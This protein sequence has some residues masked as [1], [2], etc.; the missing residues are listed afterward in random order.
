[1]GHIGIHC[2]A[3]EDTFWPEDEPYD[4]Y[5]FEREAEKAAGLIPPQ[6]EEQ[7]VHDLDQL[8]LNHSQIHLFNRKYVEELPLIGGVSLIK[9]PKDSGKTQLLAKLTTN[10]PLRILLIGHRRSLIQ[11]MCNRL[12]LHC[13]LDDG[14]EGSKH[15]SKKERQSQ[16]GVCVDSLGKLDLA[17]PYDFVLIDESEQVLSHFSSKTL[18]GKR[19]LMF[20]YFMRLIEQAK[21]VVAL[22]A[23]LSWT[24]ANFITKWARKEGPVKPCN[25]YLNK[26]RVER[27]DVHIIEKKQQIFGEIHQAIEA[28]QKIYVAAN[29]R[30]Q[31]E[32]IE[33]AIRD[34]SPLVSMLAITSETAKID[35][36]DSA[37]RDFLLAPAIAAKKYQVILASP[38]AGTGIDITFDAAEIYFD[39]VFGIFIHDITSHFDCD[40]QLARV[41]HPGEVRVF[42]SPRQFN[43]ETNMDVMKHDVI[44]MM[45]DHLLTGLDAQGAPVYNTNDPLL[46]LVA[47][48]ASRDRASINNLKKNFIDYKIRQGWT[49]IQADVDLEASE[50][51]VL[52]AERGKEITDEEAIKR[53]MDARSMQPEEFEATKKILK[54][55]GY[56]SQQVRLD[57]RRTK[58]ERSYG[59]DITPEL[60][61]FDDQGRGRQKVGLFRAATNKTALKIRAMI[62]QGQSEADVES[63]TLLHDWPTVQKMYLEILSTLPIYRDGEFLFDTYFT[64]D[65]LGEFVSY[66]LDNKAVIEAQFKMEVRRDLIEKP[67]TMAGD[68]LRAAGLDTASKRTTGG[69]RKY[70]L[71]EAY[72]DYM[73]KITYPEEKKS[74]PDFGSAG[75][76]SSTIH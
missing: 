73:V 11:S 53:L 44:S 14:L 47:A 59:Q 74:V 5:S 41:R 2:S 69:G 23:D 7:I 26:H 57:Y 63:P 51:G 30:N 15:K 18:A 46:D 76:L 68:F 17:T 43:Y 75:S 6:P 29:S 61:V 60:I 45:Q 10:N 35:K 24:T 4:F 71:N 42:V 38:S 33:A 67:T 72:Y 32:I 40:Q 22:D 37:V 3:C 48:V 70:C 56:V 52:M 36:E 21:S 12:G 27:G 34:K 54:R 49:I 66:L 20:L 50:T 25:I 19:N 9:S 65:D 62:A 55:Q 58:I 13:Y 64:K 31:I 16:Y 39:K 1:M 8:G 28:G